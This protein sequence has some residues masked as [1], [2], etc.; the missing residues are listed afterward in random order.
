M[1]HVSCFMFHVSCFN[2]KARINL[3]SGFFY[4]TKITKYCDLEFGISK[5][6]NFKI[7]NLK[8]LFCQPGI[9]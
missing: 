6:W 9:L 7:L 8:S 4:Y 3:D 5:N 2:K 1:F